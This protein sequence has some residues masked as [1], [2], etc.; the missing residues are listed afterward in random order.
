MFISLYVLTLPIQI[1]IKLQI[2]DTGRMSKASK[3]FQIYRFVLSFVRNAKIKESAFHAVLIHT[4]AH[5]FPYISY[6][7]QRNE[8]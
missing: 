3:G 6:R 7:L 4:D 5:H 2:D 1:K 8:V